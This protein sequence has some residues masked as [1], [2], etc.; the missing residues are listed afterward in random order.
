MLGIQLLGLMFGIFMIYWTFLN[1]KRSKLSKK[2]WMI[3]LV[4]W[5]IFLIITL[6]P[7]ILNPILETLHLY[8]AMDFYLSIGFLFVIGVMFHMYSIIKSCQKNIEDLTRS[9]AHSLVP[10]NPPKEGGK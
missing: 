5:G 3:W 9:I 2:E 1:Y 7:G 4:I 6:F 10:K 8:R